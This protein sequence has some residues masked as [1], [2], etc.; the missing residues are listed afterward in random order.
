M[1]GK[2]WVSVVL[3]CV[4]GVCLGAAAT[5]TQQVLFGSGRFTAAGGTW[6]SL[7]GLAGIASLISGVITFIKGLTSKQL[8]PTQQDIVNGGLGLLSTLLSGKMDAVGIT[9][10]AALAVLFADRAVAK[11]QRGMQMVSDLAKLCL[12]PVPAPPAS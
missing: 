12:E 11:D 1:N 2:Q 4:G 6:T 9:K 7:G 3:I 8:S 10:H 5:S